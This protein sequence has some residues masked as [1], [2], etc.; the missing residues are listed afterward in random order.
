MQRFSHFAFGLLFLLAVA[1]CEGK[2]HIPERKLVKI[3]AEMHLTDALLEETRL[4]AQLSWRP[5][6]T[7]VYVAI[8]DKYG[9]TTEQLYSTLTRY[10]ASKSKSEKLYDKVCKQLEKQQS[11]ARSRVEDLHS[12]QNRWTQEEEYTFSGSDN[13]TSRLPF[14][15]PVEGLG[16]YILEANVALYG[17][18]SATRPRMTMYLYAEAVDSVLLQVEQEVQHGEDGRDYSLAIANRDSAATHV[19]GYVFNRDSDSLDILPR[20][21]AAKGIKLRFLPSDEDVTPQP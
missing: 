20:H 21:A 3:L 13:D 8:L 15:I 6:S 18:D 9:Y 1:A 11:R 12:Q 16:E 19:R 10:G 7:A 4:S 5:D 14:S 17:G 2:K